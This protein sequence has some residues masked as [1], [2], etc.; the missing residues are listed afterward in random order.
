MLIAFLIRD[1]AD[2]AS[3]KQSMA[4]SNETSVVRFANSKT[5]PYDHGAEREGA[6]DEVETFDD[7]ED[8][9]TKDEEGDGELIDPPT[10]L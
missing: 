3:W 2:W 5:S 8:G 10:Q 6:V 7:D 4:R 9:L 1:A